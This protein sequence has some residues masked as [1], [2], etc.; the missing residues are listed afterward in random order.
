M[1]KVYAILT[2]LQ[3]GKI[4]KPTIITQG[5]VVRKLCF[6]LAKNKGVDRAG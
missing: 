4:P 2:E 3:N 5:N 1:C 6:D